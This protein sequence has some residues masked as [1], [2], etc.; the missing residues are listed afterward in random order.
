MGARPGKP[1]RHRRLRGLLERDP[2]ITDRELAEALGVSVQTIRLDR[3]ELG[4]P[5]ARERTRRVAEEATKNVRSVM[6][7]EVI[8]DLTHLSL[9]EEGVSVLEPTADMAFRR[10]GIVRGHHIFAQANSLAVALVDAEVALTGTACIRFLRP[11][12]AGAR[13][14][15][16]A[17]VTERAGRRYHVDVVSQVAGE[18]V[19]RGEFV[20][21]AVDPSPGEVRVEGGS[22]HDEDRP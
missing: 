9:G 13:L 8:G 5:E 20:V 10:T 1:E 2:F 12:R 22:V 16:R 14:V 3:L 17:R 21:F 11:V 19:F 18:D 15:A 4:I 7:G 6:T